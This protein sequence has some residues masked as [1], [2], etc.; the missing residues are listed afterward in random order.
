MGS[1]IFQTNVFSLGKRSSQNATGRP[2]AKGQDIAALR[3]TS[4]WETGYWVLGREL[5]SKSQQTTVPLL[6]L[7]LFFLGLEFLIC[8]VVKSVLTLS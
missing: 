7:Y 5:R 2:T 3:G 1:P 8:Q 6:G 4:A